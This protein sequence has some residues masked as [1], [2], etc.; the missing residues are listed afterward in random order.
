MK[1]DT[2]LDDDFAFWDDKNYNEFINEK[3]IFTP[4]CVPIRHMWIDDRAVYSARIEDARDAIMQENISLEE[5]KI[6]W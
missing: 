3:R 6:R 1:K 4:T 2:D 5:L